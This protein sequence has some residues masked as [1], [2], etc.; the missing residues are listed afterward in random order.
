MFSTCASTD[1][2]SADTASSRMIRRGLKRQRAGDVHP[3]A[4]AAR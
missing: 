1:L 2:S 4:L 3:L